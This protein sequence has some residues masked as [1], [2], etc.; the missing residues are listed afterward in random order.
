MAQCCKNPQLRW[1]K[2]AP[3]QKR[4]HMVRDFDGLTV[5]SYYVL[6]PLVHAYVCRNCGWQDRPSQEQVKPRERAA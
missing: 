3:M 2:R 5:Q 6:G 1:V 4:T